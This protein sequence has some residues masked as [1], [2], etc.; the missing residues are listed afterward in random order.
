MN[1]QDVIDFFDK[2]APHWD[3]DMVRN[4]EVISSILTLA[5]VKEGVDVLDVACGTGVLFEDYIKRGVRSLTAIDV[6]PKM[7][8]IAREK[9]PD[10]N[11]ICGDVENTKFDKK[12]DVV[13]VYNA[14]PHFP[15]P[16]RL[17]ATLAGLVKIGGRLCVAHSM[18]REA[19]HEHHKH[20]SNV[21][22]E[23]PEAE[24][25]KTIF[26]PYFDVDVAISTEKSYQ[27]SGIRKE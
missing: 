8:Q 26:S 16:Q 1:K 2:Q 24:E 21:S 14:F 23:L 18:S 25:L 12:F 11:V 17:I 3:A 5:G 15:D 9:Y 10:I 20:A 27:V 19:L 4:E 6:S 22:I 13:M 7:V